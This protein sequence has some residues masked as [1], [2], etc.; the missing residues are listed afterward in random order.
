MND[1][2]IHGLLVGG[3]FDGD[4]ESDPRFFKEGLMKGKDFVWHEYSV[5]ERPDGTKFFLYSGS[6]GSLNDR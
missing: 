3:P 5:K 1:N 4:V 2:S 6:R